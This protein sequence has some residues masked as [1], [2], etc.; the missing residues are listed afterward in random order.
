MSDWSGGSKQYKYKPVFTP[1]R[2]GGG[3]RPLAWIILLILVLSQCNGRFEP[4]PA[5]FTGPAWDN[6]VAAVLDDGDYLNDWLT[7]MDPVCRPVVLQVG[8]R[9]AGVSGLSSV[10]ALDDDNVAVW[11]A[12]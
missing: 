11:Y 5:C 8:R 2:G 6:Y 4:A 7:H 1:K 3:F 9:M 10:G 12:R